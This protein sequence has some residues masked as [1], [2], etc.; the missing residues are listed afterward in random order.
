MTR[1]ARLRCRRHYA[2]GGS[3]FTQLLRMGALCLVGLGLGALPGWSQQA[4]A[5]SA[6]SPAAAPVATPAAGSGEL[7]PIGQ[8]ATTG[9]GAQAARMPVIST[10]DFVRMI[11]VLVAV[12]G[13]IYLV[14]Y[15]LRRTTRKSTIENDL[16]TVLGSKSLAGNRSLHLVRVGRSVYLVGSAEGNVGLVSEISE[17]ESVDELLLQA[18]KQRAAGKKTFSEILGGLVPQGVGQLA[19]PDGLGFV[20]RQKDRLRKLRSV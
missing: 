7:T 11:L 6:L 9:S 14:F 5:G 19:L 12:I 4:K 18:G 3:G 1:I 2:G 10:W 20:R 13:V 17:K 16:I 8:A 15:L